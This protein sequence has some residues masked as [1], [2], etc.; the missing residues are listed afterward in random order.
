MGWW[1]SQGVELTQWTLATALPHVQNRH[2]KDVQYFVKNKNKLHVQ[3]L[4][5]E[6]TSCFVV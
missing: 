4:N 3:H 2:F 1:S 6:F 5:N